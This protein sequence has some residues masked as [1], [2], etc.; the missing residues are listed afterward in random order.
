M[1]E[2]AANYIQQI[3]AFIESKIEFLNLQGN[4]LG[5]DGVIKI[6]R[7]LELNTTLNDIILAD[8]QFGEKKAVIDRIC[9]VLKVHPSLFQM[10]LKHNGIYPDGAEQIVAAV[11]KRMACK[12]EMSDRFPAELSADIIA[13]MGKIK[14]K[15]KAKGRMGGM[16]K[17]G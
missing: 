11:K 8:N 15:K 17:K 10:D 5:N 1:D 12:V 4:Y 9:E 13:V 14:P 3:L 16:K 6:M 2:N 7:A